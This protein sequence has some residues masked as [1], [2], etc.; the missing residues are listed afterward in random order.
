MKSRTRRSSDIMDDFDDDESDEIAERRAKVVDIF[1]GL[2]NTRH[3]YVFSQLASMASADPFEKIKGLI[4]DMI[5]KLL[6]EAQE[7]A[8]HEAFCNEEMGKTKA[9]QEDKEMKLEKFTSRVDEAESKIAEL[10]QA[11]KTLSAEVG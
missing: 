7:E 3:S 4:N 11:I 8:T 9:S 2:A 1:K 5:E 6:K 10:S